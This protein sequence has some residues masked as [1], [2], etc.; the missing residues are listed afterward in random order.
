MQFAKFRTHKVDPPTEY[1]SGKP[2]HFAIMGDSTFDVRGDQKLAYGA[3]KPVIDYLAKHNKVHVHLLARSGAKS[4]DV[5]S[6]QLPKLKAI[7]HVD[8]VFVYMGANDAF[9]LKN[10]FAVGRNYK[11]LLSYTNMR[12]IP[13]LASEIANYWHLGAILIPGRLW[14]Y[15]AIHIQNFAIKSAVAGSKYVALVKVK[16]YHK[17]VHK[18]RRVNPYLLDGVHPTD[19]AAMEWGSYLLGQAIHDQATASVFSKS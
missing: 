9:G 17:Q 14:L 4:R 1:G 5:V 13:V 7:P 8:L 16:E 11:T 12:K 18:N 2:F 19:K 15:T 3:A 10:P 6:D